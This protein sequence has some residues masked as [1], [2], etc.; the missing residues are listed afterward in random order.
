MG[1]IDRSFIGTASEPRTIEVEKGHL[2]FF[3]KA[4]GQTDPIYFDEAAAR[5]AGHPALPAPP[6]FAFSLGLGARA[7]KGDAFD[8]IADLRKILHGEQSFTYHHVLYAGDTVTLV[9]TTQDIYEKRNGA[10]EFLVQDTAFTNQHGQLCVEMR[11][12][13]VVRNS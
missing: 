12:V 3:A 2:K 6:T 9:T 1:V 13:T 10:L 11:T 7:K 5:A 4:T 8:I